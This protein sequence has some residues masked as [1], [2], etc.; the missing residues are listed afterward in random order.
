M[1]IGFSLLANTRLSLWNLTTVF[2]TETAF[3]SIF[4][5][6]IY[7][8]HDNKGILILCINEIASLRKQTSLLA[9]LSVFS[10][11]EIA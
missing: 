5:F 10:G 9:R 6:C 4:T 2:K 1:T 8:L 11:Y 3:P 7:L